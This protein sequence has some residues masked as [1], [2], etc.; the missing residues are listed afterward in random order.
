[1]NP[2]SSYRRRQRRAKMFFF[3]CMASVPAISAVYERVLPGSNEVRPPQIGP[4][5]L[6]I[7]VCPREPESKQSNAVETAGP[8]SATMP[9]RTRINQNKTTQQGSLDYTP[10]HCLVNA[11]VPLFW[12]K[13][14]CFNGQNVSFKEPSASFWRRTP[15][16]KRSKAAPAT[17]AGQRMSVS[18]QSVATFC[19]QKSL[20]QCLAH[21]PIA[22]ASSRTARVYAGW[23]PSGG[24]IAAVF[25][26]N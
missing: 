8:T 21:R 18:R 4:T 23:D 10:E 11:V 5:H 19:T 12:R 20:R 16:P 25:S 3:V 2:R 17:S 26:E 15:Q 22:S 1:M 9:T 24:W 7:A 13:K 6:F 14:P